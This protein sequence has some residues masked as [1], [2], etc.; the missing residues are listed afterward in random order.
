MQYN[1]P[2]IDLHIASHYDRMRSSNAML[3]QM[4]I[5]SKFA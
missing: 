2:Y 3:D 5:W 4:Q 1:C